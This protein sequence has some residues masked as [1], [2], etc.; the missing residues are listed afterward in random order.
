MVVGG[1]FSGTLRIGAKVVSSAGK[2]DGF[3]ARLTATGGV[4]WLVRVG[5]PGADAVQG[6]AAAGDRIAIA[7]TFAA[8]A[9]LLGQP[10][11]PFDERSVAADGFVAELDAAGARRW[12]DSV[13]R[14][15]RRVGRRGRDRRARP[16]RDRRHRPRHRARRRRSI[17]SPAAPADGLVAWWGQAVR[18]GAQPS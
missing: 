9:D 2:T 12:A 7:G 5:G 4:A 8:G 14:Q 13:R 1:S 11:P 15:G 18:A 10:L 16:D 17:S 6:V 3:V